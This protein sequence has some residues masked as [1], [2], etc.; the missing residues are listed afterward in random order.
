MA[1]VFRAQI[2]VVVISRGSGTSYPNSTLPPGQRKRVNGKEEKAESE[3][4][5]AKPARVILHFCSDDFNSC[6]C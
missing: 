4:F 6:V 3:G 2:C 5:E 1:G